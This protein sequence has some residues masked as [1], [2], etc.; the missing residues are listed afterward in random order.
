MGPAE[1]LR[2]AESLGLGPKEL[3]HLV[4]ISVRTIRRGVKENAT[5]AILLRGIEEKLADPRTRLS[6]RALAIISARGEGLKMLISRLVH[7]YVTMDDLR[8]V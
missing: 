4:G 2:I 6:M 8:R 5:V 1:I 3:A 7:S